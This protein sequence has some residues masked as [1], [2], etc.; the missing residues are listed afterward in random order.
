MEAPDPPHPRVVEDPRVVETVDAV[1]FLDLAVFGLLPAVGLAAL[2]LTAFG[3]AA[4]GLAAVAFFAVRGLAVA[5]R[6]DEDV[7]LDEEVDADRRVTPAAVPAAVFDASVS[8]A[9]VG[10]DCVSQTTAAPAAATGH[11]PPPAAPS[12]PTPAY[13][14]IRRERGETTPTVS[15][16][17]SNISLAVWAPGTFPTVVRTVSTGWSTT[18][19]AEEDAEDA[20]AFSLIIRLISH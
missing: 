9:R 11:S 1:A 17:V 12:I 19:A 20:R 10:R 7:D 13:A 8:P 3:L 15:R 16:T 4:F 2:G 5:R 14:A 6:L 18:S